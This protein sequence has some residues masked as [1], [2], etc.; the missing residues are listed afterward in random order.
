MSRT[1]ARTPCFPC[2][3]STE[4]SLPETS[5]FQRT[6]WWRSATLVSLEMSTK[7]QTM[8]AKATWVCHLGR[9]H[10]P[11]ST[12]V[13][14]VSPLSLQARLPLKW[15]APETIFDRVYTTQSDVWSFG[16]LLWEIFSLGQWSLTETSHTTSTEYLLRV[17]SFFLLQ[18]LL[19]IQACASM[20]LSAGGLR[21]ARGWG[22]QNTPPPRCKTG[23]GDSVYQIIL[24]QQSGFI[25]IHP[26][27]DIRSCWTAGWIVPPTDPHLQSWWNIWGTCCR[28]ALNRSVKTF[29]SH[30]WANE[31]VAGLKQRDPFL[32][33]F[34]FFFPLKCLSVAAHI[35]YCC[36][37]SVCAPERHS[38][39]FATSA[40]NSS[41]IAKSFWEI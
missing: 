25:H 19:R 13:T 8:S 5:C 15:M 6:V 24:S 38:E 35:C 11:S 31:K 14:R 21:R 41:G 32:L 12:G 36:S 7:T 29:M 3:A 18:G 26:S 16:V 34:L 33:F 9:S 37:C 4:T 27:V 20:S 1:W 39:C 40:H 2:S 28:P 22:L 30:S 10:R 17:T 23:K